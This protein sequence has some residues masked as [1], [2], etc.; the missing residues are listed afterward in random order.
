[1]DDDLKK[2]IID[3]IEP[4]LHFIL[5]FTLIIGVPFFISGVWPPFVSILSESMEPNIDTGDMVFIV[6]NERYNSEYTSYGGVQ[7]IEDE[8]RK[9]FNNYGDVIVYSRN[10]NS[11]S[12]PII[13]RA[14]FYVEDNENWIHK[15]NKSKLPS[16]SCNEVTYCPAPNAGIITI[17]D[18]NNGYDQAAGISKPVKS[19]WIIGRAEYR[20]PILGT[21]RNGMESVMSIKLIPTQ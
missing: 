18:N 8:S 17:G 4:A 21:I 6:D 13:H 9:S 14:A 11:N 2:Y 1:M 5:I 12:I 3:I 15:A 7:T 16:L 10:G 19:D 20:V